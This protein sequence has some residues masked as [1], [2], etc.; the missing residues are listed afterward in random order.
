MGASWIIVNTFQNLMWHNF[1]ANPFVNTV[2]TL[3]QWE[4]WRLILTE[5]S[6]FEVYTNATSQRLTQ[7]TNARVE[8]TPV[9]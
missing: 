8:T 7:M 6:D 1:V 2:D 9:G 3:Y 4:D 5:E